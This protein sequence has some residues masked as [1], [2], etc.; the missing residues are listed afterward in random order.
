MLEIHNRCKFPLCTVD[1]NL[2]VFIVL[3]L[4][5]CACFIE[6]KKLVLQIFKCVSSCVRACIRA[7]VRSCVVVF[8]F[9]AMRNFNDEDGG[10]DNDGYGMGMASAGQP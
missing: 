6:N 2:E 7:C 8:R 1:S 4:G 3:T 9:V 5:D 10:N